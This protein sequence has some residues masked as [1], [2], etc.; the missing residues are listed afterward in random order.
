MKYFIY[1][2]LCFWPTFATAHKPSD[3]YLSINIQNDQLTGRWDIALRDLEFAL[4]L[5]TNDDGMVTWGEL[6][7]KQLEISQYAFS[8]LKLATPNKLCRYQQTNLKVD[9]HTDGKYAVLLFNGDCGTETKENLSVDYRLF[10][11]LDPQHRGLLSVNHNNVNATAVLVPGQPARH[12]NFMGE[13]SAWSEVSDFI[14]EGIWHIWIGYDHILFLFSL[15]IPSVMV[16]QRDKWLPVSTFTMAFWDVFKV[17]TAFTLA[18]SIT[19]SVAA[20]GYI[21]LPSRWVESAIAAS[22]ILVALNNVV[23]IFTDKRAFLAFAFGLIHGFGFASVLSGLGL[24]ESSKLW[25]LLGFNLGVEL[26]QLALVVAFLPIA[27]KVSRYP[28]YKTLVL[29]TCSLGIAGLACVWFMERAF[30]IAI[31]A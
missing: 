23:P 25:G 7:A 11:E 18:H 19:L 3:S 4:G 28:I 29:K 12:F 10:A 20:L 31:S 2:S 8:R 22:V 21:E 9:E 16:Y 30:D 13:A 27:Y 15:L 5:D 17:V 6:R 24:K 26:G 14:H 1:L